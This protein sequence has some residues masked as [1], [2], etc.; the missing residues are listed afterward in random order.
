VGQHPESTGGAL[1]AI[2][3]FM[4]ER[5][6]HSETAFQGKLVR[7]DVHDVELDCGRRAVREIIKHPGAA[8]I[9]AQLPD[10][11]FVLVR[12]YRK[13]IEQVL[14]EAV[15][16]TLEPGEDPD[17]CAH[18]ELEEETGYRADSLQ[19]LGIMYPAPGYSE[20]A[21]HVYFAALSPERG[22]MRPDDDERLEVEFLTEDALEALID[23]GEMRDAKTLGAWALY[24]RK[25]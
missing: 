20:E 16:G 3:E 10:Q 8:V 24:R 1:G 12:Q 18:R 5:T 7:V 19:K 22:A 23:N 2:K 21:L 11:R 6:I 25:S 17:V 15:A 13:A 14:L 4:H 9:L